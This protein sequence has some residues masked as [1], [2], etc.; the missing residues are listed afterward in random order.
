MGMGLPP[1]IQGGYSGGGGAASSD[2][3]ASANMGAPQMG[4]TGAPA[5]PPPGRGYGGGAPAGGPPVVGGL[6]GNEF[7]VQTQAA[8][9]FQQP[10]KDPFGSLGGGF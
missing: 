1:P 4:G 3:F 10:G 7:G 9:Q 2:P 5:G 6:G 8:P